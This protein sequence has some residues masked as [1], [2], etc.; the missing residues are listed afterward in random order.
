MVEKQESS[1]DALRER[2]AWLRCILETVADAIIVIDGVGAIQSFSAA[3]ERQFGYRQDEVLGSNVSML[4][5]PP[6]RD[7]HDGYMERYR[8][9]GE[10]RIIGIG[11]EVVGRRK[12]GS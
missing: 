6:Y 1:R 11:R 8:A 12:D 4:M 5:P 10:R 3:A 9:T 7:Q 2:E